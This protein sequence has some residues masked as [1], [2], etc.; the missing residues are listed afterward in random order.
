MIF[1]SSS[2]DQELKKSEPKKSENE[3][4]WEELVRN[5]T[6][7]LNLC[8]LDFTDLRDDDEKDVLA[9][10]SLGAGIPPPP[11]PQGGAI[12]PPPMMPPS[13]A[14]PPMYGYGGSLTNSVIAMQ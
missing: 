4:H 11:P 5:M 7:P 13:L 14:P 3:L 8:D 6:R 2:V 12:A 10:R 1:R 9:P